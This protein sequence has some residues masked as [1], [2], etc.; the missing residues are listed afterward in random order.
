MIIALTVIMVILA[1][2]AYIF[3]KD[4]MQEKFIGYAMTAILVGSNVYGTLVLVIL[5]SHGL[6]FL[7]FSIWKRSNNS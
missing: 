6:A 7:P 4:F 1:V 5:L 2:L 3:M